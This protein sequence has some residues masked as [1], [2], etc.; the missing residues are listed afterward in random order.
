MLSKI[1]VEFKPTFTPAGTF[2][3]TYSSGANMMTGK[4]DIA[5]YTTGFYP[6]PYTDNFLCKSVPS[7]NNQGGSNNYQVGS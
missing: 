1:G 6:D 7:K 3:G 5:G 2:F 4:F